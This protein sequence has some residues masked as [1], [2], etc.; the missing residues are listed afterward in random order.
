MLCV[1]TREIQLCDGVIFKF[2]RG[3]KN[4]NGNSIHDLV[5]QSSVF[6]RHNLAGFCFLSPPKIDFL[7]YIRGR[8]T[9]N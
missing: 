9:K 5:M 7:H 8:A 2:G 4:C 6:A 1:R 3:P